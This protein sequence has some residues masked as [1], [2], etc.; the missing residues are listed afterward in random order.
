MRLRILGVCLVIAALCSTAVPQSRGRGDG[1][2]IVISKPANLLLVAP[3]GKRC[4]HNPAGE[5]FQ[6]ISGCFYDEHPPGESSNSLELYEPKEGAYTLEISGTK[7][8]QTLYFNAH[9]QQNEISK[10]VDKN[11]PACP[12]GRADVKFQ[13]T[14]SI[15]RIKWSVKCPV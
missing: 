2:F 4:G 1:L 7:L 3:D 5:P 14:S 6:E 11:V 15:K 13:Y 9:D 10:H 12:S 8:G